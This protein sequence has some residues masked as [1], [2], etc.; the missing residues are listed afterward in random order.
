MGD[1]GVVQSVGCDQI[2]VLTPPASPMITVGVW[3][4]G[5]LVRGMGLPGEGAFVPLKLPP[6]SSGLTPLMRECLSHN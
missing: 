1:V 3:R 6:M 2:I 5:A 4:T